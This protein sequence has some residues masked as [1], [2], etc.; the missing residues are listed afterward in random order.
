[1]IRIY[2]TYWIIFLGIYLLAWASPVL[3]PGLP[4]GHGGALV[5]SLLLVPQDPT[6]VGGTGAPLLVVAWTLQYEMIF[7]FVIAAG[8]LNRLLAIIFAV[9]GALNYAD[10]IHGC[11]FPAS[12]FAKDLL[13]L[14]AFGSV[15]AWLSN[16]RIV[17]ARPV[18][19]AG[20]ALLA[21]VALAVIDVVK[22]AA[23][24]PFDRSI[25]YGLVFSVLILALVQAENRGTIFG[26][27]NQFQLL[28]DSSYALY[29]AH[30]PLLSALGKVAV[31]AGL[32]GYSGATVAFVVMLSASVCVAVLFH[33]W[34]ERPMLR[35]LSSFTPFGDAK[36]AVP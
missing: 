33:Y 29:L 28:G 18:M 24:Y 9:L 14:F 11:G 2:T 8:I 27:E 23:L 13:L 21:Y 31:F 17:I 6:V 30:L 22:G 16:G 3:R 5:R 12:F 4:G 1:L 35:V 32:R 25:A 19:L 20:V 34:L 26:G 15:V 10:C 7:Y 36:R